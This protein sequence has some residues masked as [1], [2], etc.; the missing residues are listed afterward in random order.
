MRFT[1]LR[2]R[3]RPLGIGIT[4]VVGLLAATPPAAAQDALSRPTV[5]ASFS[6]GKWVARDQLIELRLSLPVQPGRIAVVIG[7]TDW[8]SLFE[9]FP[10]RLVFRPGL[11]PLPAGIHEVVIFQITADNEW[12]ELARLPLQVL[13]AG[14][15]ESAEG[16]PVVD[17]SG[18]GQ[19]ASG[20]EPAG[21]APPR[22]T[23]H[24]VSV[25]LGGQFALARN[26]WN[27]AGQ[28]A[29]LG[30][31]HRP[32]ALRFSTRPT[33]APLVDLS[34]YLLGARNGAVSFSVGHV[35]YGNQ[36][37]LATG[38]ASRGA[39][40][41]VRLG[42]HA[43]VTLAG[44]NGSSLVGWNNF[45]GL[46]ESDHRVFAGTLGFEAIPGRPGT[47]RLEVS[48]LDGSL[49]PQFGVNDR[50]VNDA[51]DSSGL[52]FRVIGGDPSKR[53][54]L[55]AGYSRSR[56]GNPV[57]PLLAQQFSVVPV[58]DE[59]KDA[60]YLDVRYA[61]VQKTSGARPVNLAV[62]FKH[63]LVEPLFR[64]VVGDVKADIDQNAFEVSGAVGEIVAQFVHSRAHDNLDAI[65][66]ILRTNTRVSA[67]TTSV[68][69]TRSGRK[70][71]PLVTYQLNRTHQYGD[72]LPVNS[73]FLA[74]SQVPDQVSTNHVA[75]FEL[76]HAVFRA[77]YQINR[78]FQDNRQPGRVLADLLNLNNTVSLGV[79]AGTALDFTVDFAFEGAENREIGDTDV[80]RRIGVAANWRPFS[81]TLVAGN[82]ATT[83]LRN[84]G[85]TRDD[86]ATDL[87]VQLSRTIP[88][89]KGGRDKPQ[90]QLFVRYARQS[91][92]LAQ[93]LLGMRDDRH[94]WTFNT[95][96]N[97]S[98]F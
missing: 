97:I 7:Q 55:D 93:A 67:L 87:N 22:D 13:T 80:T 60:R 69:L 40:A 3:Q 43:D 50:S 57:D 25:N 5:T 70:W 9:Q 18:K 77:A 68:P 58:Q 56:F 17:V 98:L 78:S 46:Q 82:I 28:V 4:A 71:R 1:D 89:W 38:F 49:L 54:T 51:E 39:L 48:G 85:R 81:R 33:D 44:L 83:T 47:F 23:F 84:D 59:T 35:T 2:R 36:R 79:L 66:S 29:V 75:G 20:F 15:F 74:E 10:T 45:F 73:D 32:D 52:G 30:V 16:S 62:G 91:T 21:N 64:S 88:L 94:L 92:R 86:R 31:T 6:A 14:R 61:L 76:Q 27:T 63:E 72:A 95:G 65:E 34:S 90:G 12:Q 96:F 42:S 41:T 8:T 11:V 37:H 26:G 19:V 53:F 24:D